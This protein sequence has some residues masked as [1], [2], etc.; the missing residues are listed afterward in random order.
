MTAK[1]DAYLS[2][3]LFVRGLQCHKSLYLYKY[4]P[5]L[6]DELS[7]EQEALFS[8]GTDVGLLA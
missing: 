6:K 2:K 8:T 1:D 3:S 7:P 5:E 4:H